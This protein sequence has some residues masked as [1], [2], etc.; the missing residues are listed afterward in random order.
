MS[1]HFRAIDSQRYILAVGHPHKE[2]DRPL[3]RGLGIRLTKLLRQTGLGAIVPLLV[4]HLFA[5]NACRR[6]CGCLSKSRSHN[7]GRKAQSYEGEKGLHWVFLSRVKWIVNAPPTFTFR[8]LYSELTRV[9]EN[10]PGWRLRGHSNGDA[11][12]L[13]EQW[14]RRFGALIG[15]RVPT[16]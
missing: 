15:S 9:K 13:V 12:S 1:G 10:A 4:R 7:G 6:G 5:V 3:R 16:T 14:D 11:G 2:K 8:G